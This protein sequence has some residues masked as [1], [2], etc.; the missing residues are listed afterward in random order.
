[1]KPITLLRLIVF[2]FT[3]G[4]VTC[5]YA[6]DRQVLHMDL[7]VRFQGFAG[8][9]VQPVHV[10]Q[11]KGF[12]PEKTVQW[13]Y[14]CCALSGLYKYHMPIFPG[15]CPGL[16]CRCPF[17]ASNQNTNRVKSKNRLNRLACISQSGHVA[18][19]ANVTAAGFDGSGL[20]GR[21]HDAAADRLQ[22]S[23]FDG[24]GLKGRGHDSPGQR[25]GKWAL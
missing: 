6:F 8:Q 19:A 25:P 5:L 21:G 9:A 14:S 10:L 23:G 12:F 1:M 16:K 20:K 7:P 15:R 24:S 11:M 2:S 13:K 4:S 17:G 3:T 18:T 22:K